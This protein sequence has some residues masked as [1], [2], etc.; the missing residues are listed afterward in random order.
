MNPADIGGVY[1]MLQCA[2]EELDRASIAGQRAAKTI[3]EIQCTSVHVG[4]G[5][6]LQPWHVTVCRLQYKTYTYHGHERQ[7]WT[8]IYFFIDVLFPGCNNSSLI[9]LENKNWVHKVEFNLKFWMTK[10]QIKVEALV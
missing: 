9:T 7:F 1:E 8:F 4:C 6:K 3:R 10:L 2:A 5:H